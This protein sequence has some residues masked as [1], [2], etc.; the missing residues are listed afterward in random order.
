LKKITLGRY[1]AH[2]FGGYLLLAFSKD[3]QKLNEGKPIVFDAKLEG[4]RLTLS[5]NLSKIDNVKEV[6]S[7][8]K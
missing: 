8:V 4:S 3:W 5:T 2:F 6:D 1:L 7:I